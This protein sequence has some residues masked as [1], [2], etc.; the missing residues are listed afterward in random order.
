MASDYDQLLDALKRR[1]PASELDDLGRESGFIRRIRRI[2]GSLFAW[3]L[4]LSRFGCGRPGFRQAQHRFQQMAGCS[5]WPRPFQMRL[6]QQEVIAF[7]CSAFEVAVESWRREHRPKHP[8]AHHFADIV[9]WDASAVA[10]DDALASCFKGLRKAA[11]QLKVMLAVSVFGQLPL[12][13]ELVPGNHSDSRMPPPLELFRRGTLWLFDNAF[14]TYSVLREV[15]RAQ[16]FYLCPMRCHGRAM[17]VGIHNAP[18]RVRDALKRHPGGVPLET[19]LHKTGKVTKVWDLD[20]LVR[21]TTGNDRTAVPTRLVIVPSKKK[22]R[23]Y[24]TNLDVRWSPNAIIELYRLRWQIELTF[25]ELKQDLNLETVPTKDPIAAQAFLWA[26]LIALAVSRT[27]CAALV[28]LNELAGLASKIRPAVVTRTLRT[29]QLLLLRA[30]VGPLT[31]AKLALQLL[32]DST[33]VEAKRRGPPR[34]DSFRR[35]TEL[36]PMPA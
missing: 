14:A 25:K 1:L 2:T 32:L 19:L 30:I 24:L 26:S 13:A 21:P 11:S 7:L 5:V 9:A 28:P 31:S 35:L 10:L 17:I 22:P 4:I 18:R 36:A 27:V 6:K 3:A 15:Q 29:L 20:V 23:R 34:T 16:Q 12:A 33:E 8:L